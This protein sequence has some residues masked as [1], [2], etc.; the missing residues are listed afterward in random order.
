MKIPKISIEHKPVQLRTLRAL[1]DVGGCNGEMKA[2][3]IVLMTLPPQ[4]PHKCDMCGREISFSKA[5]PYQS[6]VPVD[7]S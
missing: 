3:N 7:Q 4:Y 1:C 6:L 2:T 5:Y